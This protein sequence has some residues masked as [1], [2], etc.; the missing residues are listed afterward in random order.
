MKIREGLEKKILMATQ[1]K[2]EIMSSRNILR[3]RIV[4]FER[5]IDDLKRV[6]DEHKR[7]AE[8]L[9]KEKD[10]L[11]KQLQ[12]QQAVQ[13]D[14]QKLIYIQEQTKK[15]LEL[16]LDTFFIESGKQKKI[17]ST[18]ERERDRL[19]EEQIELTQTIQDNMEDIREKKGMIF[20]L[21][22]NAA[23]AEN[24]IR[25]QQNL[26]EAMRSDRNSLQKSLQ[27]SNAE[28]NELKKKLKILFHQIEQLKED[29]GMKEKLL[30]KDENVMRKMTKETENLRYRI[31]SISISFPKTL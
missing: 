21:K 24:K 15:K 10:I 16:E 30:I 1:E 25:Q 22:K 8:G 31:K 13:A 28:C 3:H 26:Y 12:R 14:T 18:L 4:S 29:I 2:N 6:I 11:N 19:A 27:E 5:E 23:E 20:D 9:V 7:M 17:I